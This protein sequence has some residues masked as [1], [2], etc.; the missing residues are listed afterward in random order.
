MTEQMNGPMNGDASKFID[1]IDPDDPAYQREMQRPAEVK[2]DVTQMERRKRVSLILNSL[3]FREELEHIAVEQ[4]SKGPHPNSILA[5]SSITELLLPQAKF[6]QSAS[7]QKG[8]SGGGTIVPVNDIKGQDA[9]YYNKG[10]RLLRCKLAAT[11]RLVDLYGWTHGIYNH[12]T[13]RV[14]QDLEHF[15][16]N[17]FGMLYHEVTAASLVKVDMQGDIIDPGVTNLGINTAGYTLHSAIHQAR[18][19]IRVIIHLHTPAAVAVSAMKEGLMP[20][21][22]EACIVGA[23]SYHEYNGIVD[24]DEERDAIARNLGVTNKVMF[25]RNHGVVCCG[26]TIEEAWHYAFN[27]MHACETQV[28]LLPIGEEN[29]I[30]IPEDVQQKTNEFANVGGGGVD[31]SARKWRLGELEF[32]ALMRHLD[33]AGFRTGYVYRD[34]VTKMMKNRTASEVEIPPAVTAVGESPYEDDMDRF[35]SPIKDALTRQKQQGKSVWLNSPNVYSKEEIKEIGT[36]NPKTITKWKDT[37]SP[38]RVGTAVKIEGANAFVVPGGDTKEL[39][40]R[41][42]EIRKVFSGE[43]ITSGPQSKVLE[44][45][46]WEEAKEDGTGELKQGIQIGAASKGIIQRDHQHNAV[47]YKQYYAANPFDNVT[48]DDVEAY[49]KEIERK[50][51]GEPESPELTPGP[52]GQLISSEERQQQLRESQPQETNIDDPAP[53]VKLQRSSSD[54]RPEQSPQLVKELNDN[55]QRSKSERKP[56]NKSKAINGDD[57]G[58]KSDTMPGKSSTEASP[59]KAATLPASTSSP[60]KEKKKK[61]KFR[62]PSFS[63]KKDKKETNV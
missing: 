34:P 58:N 36:P 48:Q 49:Q 1:N 59:S 16:I 4:L 26:A 21:C 46:T 15:L 25:L 60:Q 37:G 55:F 39:K 33:N 29:I 19:D 22:Q 28:R 12:I 11:Y 56:K 18:P 2:E 8:L 35:T 63:K 10:E 30:R 23:C 6:N 52:D 24:G 50:A 5:L 20:V 40:A 62:M 31:T 43:K 38:T 41:T 27:L 51:R 57:A 14:S 13:V 9:K 47:V 7:L 42:Q 44:G 17:P 53:A 45:T 32:E 61:K 3:Q 54:R